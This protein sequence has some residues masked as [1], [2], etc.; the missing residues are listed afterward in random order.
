VGSQSGCLT[1]APRGGRPDANYHHDPEWLTD[2]FASA[3]ARPVRLYVD[4]GQIE[5]LLASNRRFAAVL[6][7]R[8]YAHSYRE[9]PSGHNWTTWEQGLEPGLLHLFGDDAPGSEEVR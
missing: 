9:H 4:T 8:R 6:A 3:P 7:D 2:L 5:W 1:A